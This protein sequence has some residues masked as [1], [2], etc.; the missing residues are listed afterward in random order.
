MKIGRK[1][2]VDWM[3]NGGSQEKG[4]L[5]NPIHRRGYQLQNYV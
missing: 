4:F 3:R 1:L 5:A 2:L